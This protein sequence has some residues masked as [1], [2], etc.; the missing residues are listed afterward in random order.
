MEFDELFY[1][2]IV[3]IEFEEF[4]FSYCSRVRYDI[5]FYQAVPYSVECRSSYVRIVGDVCYGEVEFSFY[6]EVVQYPYD[7]GVSHKVYECRCIVH[8][9]NR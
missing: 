6:E 1:F 7:W 2:C 4:C 5:V 8:R 9:F 3:R